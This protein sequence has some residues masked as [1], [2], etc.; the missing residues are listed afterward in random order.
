M[1][2]AIIN[3][4]F[5]VVFLS[6]G[7]APGL[8]DADIYEGLVGHW[9]FDETSGATA[10]D[11]SANNNHGTIYGAPQWAAGYVRGGLGLD[12]TDDYVELPIGSLIR[13]TTSLPSINRCIRLC[14]R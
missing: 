2:K 8:A 6:L 10:E 1:T 12:G 4:M 7:L 5:S 13:G 3:Y 9:K 14:A 11:S